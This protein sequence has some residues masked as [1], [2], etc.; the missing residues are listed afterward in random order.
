[1]RIT[2]RKLLTGASAAVVAAGLPESLEALTPQQRAVVLGG[3][4]VPLLLDR[5]SGSGALSGRVPDVR[6]PAW[7]A[8]GSAGA[9]LTVSGNTLTQTSTGSSYSRSD[10]SGVVKEAGCIFRVSSV[11]NKLI[12]GGTAANGAAMYVNIY[13]SR[14]AAFY[15]VSYVLNGTDTLITA[16]TALAS[17]IN[18]NATSIASGITATSS[19]ATVSV[20]ATECPRLAYATTGGI[21]LSTSGTPSPTIANFITGQNY[22]N[23]MLHFRLGVDGAL[24]WTFYNGG[25]VAF[26]S[27]T[28]NS[29]YTGLT[30]N[31]DYTYRCFIGPPYVWGGLWKGS[32]LVNSVWA[33]DTGMSTYNGNSVFFENGLDASTLSYKQAWAYATNGGVSLAAIQAATT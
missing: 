26:Q 15:Q 21:A 8:D 23:G 17:V 10:T 2:R 27:I 24:D 32:T 25:Q 11:V 14:S 30:A 28:R 6:G 29:A 13:P 12:V 19:G 7:A 16:A 22:L 33:Q 18:S 5:F 20:S 4:A 3:A 31:T 9:S 1:M